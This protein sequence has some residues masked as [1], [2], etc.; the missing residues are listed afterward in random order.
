MKQSA[1]L[2]AR[3]KGL[4]FRQAM[5]PGHKG[6]PAQLGQVCPILAGAMQHNGWLPA[7]EIGEEDFDK[8]LAAFN[9]TELS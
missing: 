1:E 2:W 9:E 4:P 5:I 6:Q 8:G 7:D 3:A